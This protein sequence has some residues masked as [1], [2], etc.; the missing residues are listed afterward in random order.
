[1]KKKICLVIVVY[2]GKLKT[3]KKLI[4]NF[5][6]INFVVYF[7]NF[8]KKPVIRNI[9]HSVYLNENI[10]KSRVLM[11]KGLKFTILVEIFF[12]QIF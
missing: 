9:Q 5:R 2:P 3:L 12:K 4:K 6:K 11:I 7:N 8:K 10:L 1:M